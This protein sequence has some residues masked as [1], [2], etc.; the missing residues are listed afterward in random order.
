MCVCVCVCEL[1]FERVVS[2]VESPP[3]ADLTLARLHISQALA[4]PEFGQHGGVDG[5]VPPVAV[6]VVL[7][8]GV[9]L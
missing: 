5:L 9:S 2:T 1:E 8:G 3:R 6:C 7:R 4:P